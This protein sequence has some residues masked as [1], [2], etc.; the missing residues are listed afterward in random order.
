MAKGQG[1]ER[2]LS[3]LLS[4]WVSN[5]GNKD[6]FWR[7][8]AS[9]AFATNRAKVG[10]TLVRNTVGDIALMDPESEDGRWFVSHFAI[11]AKFEKPKN[12][13]PGGEGWKVYCRYWDKLSD[14][15]FKAGVFP[16][17]I[18]KA[19]LHEPL[20]LFDGEWVNS[21]APFI[22]LDTESHFYLKLPEH[23]LNA[24]FLGE[25]L[26]RVKFSDFKRQLA[27]VVK[28]RSRK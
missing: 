15:S 20:I 2:E 3:R 26:R 21:Y 4:L 6:I 23:Q 9:G 5:G 11:E 7:A 1:W 27:P 18:V 24:Y 13:W 10:K 16:I 14:Q 22:H 8:R 17:L 25:F 28:K 12:M 19:N